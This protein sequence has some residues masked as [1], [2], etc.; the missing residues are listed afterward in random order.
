MPKKTFIN[1]DEDKQK[2]I[3]NQA[4]KEFSEKG[5]KNGNIG[6]I[7]KNAGVSKGS[8]YQYFHDKKELCLY[9]VKLAWDI[10][11]KY[12]DD[13]IKDCYDM[14][15]F[16]Y[17]YFGYK[18]AWM[19]FT[20]ERDVYSFLQNIYIDIKSD[21]SGDVLNIIRK[22]S[23]ASIKLIKQ[24]I[25]NNKKHGL[26]RSEISTENIFLYISAV[27][28]KF[29]EGMLVIAKDKGKEVYDMSFE[30]FEPFIKDMVSLM[31]NGVG[32]K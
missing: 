32:T 13:A 6:V 24:M 10:S 29:K 4:M 22:E 3:I 21:I 19:L 27:S 20:D 30:D 25:E 18:K 5:Y 8:M 7:A 16:D 9:C 2:K 31:K 14:S 26:I 15:I 12:V 11:F 1:L 28:S 17:T 23:E